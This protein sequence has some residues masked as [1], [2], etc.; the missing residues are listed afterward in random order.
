MI[1]TTRRYKSQQCNRKK[2]DTRIPHGSR[3]K[4]ISS[5]LEG[6]WGDRSSIRAGKRRDGNVPFRAL[7]RKEGESPL[8]PTVINLWCCQCKE[9]TN[10]E[11]SHAN[12]EGDLDIDNDAIWIFGNVRPLYRI[13]EHR[14]L[15]CPSGGRFIPVDLGIPFICHKRLTEFLV[16]YGKYDMAVKAAMPYSWQS[17]S[18]EPR[19]YKEIRNNNSKQFVLEGKAK[20][21]ST[22][23]R[24][25]P[26]SI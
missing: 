3:L 9:K 13:K 21:R 24:S 1:K 12:K 10:V 11:G 15:R 4:P 25:S 20:S 14:C 2:P 16:D 7:L 26:Y 18:A 6:V 23:Y 8:R 5:D 17:S 22:T 19:G